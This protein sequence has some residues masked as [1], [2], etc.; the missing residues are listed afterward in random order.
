MPQPDLRV[1]AR[2]AD[3]RHLP[4]QRGHLRCQRLLPRRHGR[5]HLPLGTSVRVRV[6]GNFM[7]E[8]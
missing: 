7:R 5:H 3:L 4:R 2:A 6:N 8:R 1:A